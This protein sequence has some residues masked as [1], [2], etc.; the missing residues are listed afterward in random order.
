MRIML[1]KETADRAREIHEF[2]QKLSYGNCIGLELK[3]PKEID[4]LC[5]FYSLI[6]NEVDEL[7]KRLFNELL[8]KMSAM[9]K[10]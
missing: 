1:E 9:G 6:M 10:V 4:E 8:E 2:F 7:G 5:A 3:E